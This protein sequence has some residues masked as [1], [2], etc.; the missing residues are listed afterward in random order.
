MP[1]LGSRGKRPKRPQRDRLPSR[2]SRTAEETDTRLDAETTRGIGNTAAR[3][4][5]ER[6]GD[7]EAETPSAPKD[8]KSSSSIRRLE[9]AS[10][11]REDRNRGDHSGESPALEPNPGRKRGDRRPAT[12]ASEASSAQNIEPTNT[13]LTP[14]RARERTTGCDQRTHTGYAISGMAPETRNATGAAA[15]GNAE[16]TT[17]GPIDFNACVPG[18]TRRPRRDREHGRPKPPPSGAR[19]RRTEEAKAP[20]NLAGETDPISMADHKRSSR[21]KKS[22]REQQ[23]QAAETPRHE[24]PNEA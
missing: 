24:R 22:R 20:R 7:A 2:G 11:Q 21:T 16:P 14:S 8:E 6:E 5:R 12:A 13:A 4:S 9:P 1:L 15:S 10:R 19:F 3:S 17:D 18:H 23:H